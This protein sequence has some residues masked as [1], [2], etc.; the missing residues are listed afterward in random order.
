MKVIF[1]LKKRYSWK[2]A[3]KIVAVAPKYHHS[4]STPQ[5]T[6]GLSFEVITSICA[7]G[8]FY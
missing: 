1:C 3:A 4:L 6:T 7:L 8:I 5:K 2:I